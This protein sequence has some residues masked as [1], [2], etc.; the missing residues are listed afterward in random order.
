MV[1]YNKEIALGKTARKVTFEER[2]MVFSR[3]IFSERGSFS[4]I[5]ATYELL[6]A[7]IVSAKKS[8]GGISFKLADGRK[9]SVSGR[10]VK[11][12][13]GM[14]VEVLKDNEKKI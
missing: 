7:D 8:F 2:K 9:F 11:D 1:E 12:T 14:F 10:G 6:Y 13:I 5:S 3:P 4:N